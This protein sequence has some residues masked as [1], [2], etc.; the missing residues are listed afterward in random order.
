M[1]YPNNQTFATWSPAPS[2][3]VA[4]MVFPTRYGA[5]A[6]AVSAEENKL[7]DVELAGATV[8]T[9]A[10]PPDVSYQRLAGAL[11]VA[12]CMGLVF[13]AAMELSKVTNPASIRGVFLI[14]KS[15]MLK[16]FLSAT[17][18]SALSFAV[19]AVAAPKRM[20]AARKEFMGCGC[21]K[22]IPAVVLGAFL[23]G[24]GMALAGSCPGMVLIQIGS[25]VQN[26]WVTVLGGLAAAMLY[27]A[28][29]PSFEHLLK[30]GRVSQVKL[31]D[32]SL[33]NSVAFH[34]LAVGL[35][36]L[37]STVVALFEI[38]LPW[39]LELPTRVAP[40][41]QALP[42]SAMGA[43]VGLLQ[44]PCVL[45]LG[46]TLGSSSAYMTLASTPAGISQSLSAATP[47]LS[48]YRSGLGNWWQVVYLFGA[49]AGAAI[50]S[51]ATLTLGTTPGVGYAEAFIGGFVMILGS[52]L[53][54]GCT[55][56]HGLS[57][58]ALL[59]V[60][61]IVAVPA[62]FAGGILVAFSYQAID[63]TYRM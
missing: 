50:S 54:S 39:D 27:G 17:A 61:S 49:A 8:E 44:V 24:C 63:P 41:A 37:L 7:S 14:E 35:F 34:K 45:F 25:N 23:L 9:A 32:F 12:A 16:M 53:A 59:A 51:S 13:G 26:A 31:E 62:M 11:F 29:V 19:L 52:R 28:F 4:I 6:V 22:G 48:K 2:P 33:L 21:G 57:G 58:F 60:H 3:S 36:V 46:D 10:D 15:L 43:I 40:G 5:P 56:G 30:I 1:S 18:T 20:E 55:S 42:P 47:H 38:F